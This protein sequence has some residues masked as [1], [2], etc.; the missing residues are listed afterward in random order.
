MIVESGSVTMDLDVNQ[1]NGIGSTL[2]S[3]VRLQFAVAANSFFS[4][5]VF[6]DLLQRPGS[7]VNGAWS[8]KTLRRLFLCL[9][10]LPLGNS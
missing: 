1:L 8:H 7:W 6:N 3:T 2:Q 9:M 4:I 5:L 10:A